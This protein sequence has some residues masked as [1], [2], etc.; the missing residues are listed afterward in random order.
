LRYI[1]VWNSLAKV[2]VSKDVQ[3]LIDSMVKKS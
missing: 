2:I 3:D 1:K